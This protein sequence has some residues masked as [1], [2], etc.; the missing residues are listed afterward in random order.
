MI[1]SARVF[2]GVPSIAV[3]TSSGSSFPTAGV[4]GIDR[5]DLR[6]DRGR[7]DLLAVGAQRD[8]GGDLLR[9]LHVLEVDLLPLLRRRRRAG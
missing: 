9:V 8:R 4:P 7:D 1:T 5:V 3:I 2:T 6:A